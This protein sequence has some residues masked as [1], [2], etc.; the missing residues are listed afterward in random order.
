MTSPLVPVSWSRSYQAQLGARL[1]AP[2]LLH[3]DYALFKAD[4][5]Y[6]LMERDAVLAAAFDYRRTLAAGTE[7]HLEPASPAPV[8]RKVAAILESLLR[9]VERFGQ[10][11]YLLANAVIRGESWAGIRGSWRELSAAG[12]AVRRWWVVD[13]LVDVDK[14]RFQTTKESAGRYCWQIQRF[15]PYGLETIDRRHYVRHVHN[16]YEATL[17]RGEGCGPK[18]FEY[19]KIKAELLRC[20]MQFVDRTGTPNLVAKVAM[21]EGDRRDPNNSERLN[22]WLKVLTRMRA[23]NVAAYDAQDEIEYLE[24]QGDGS[25]I[26]LAVSYVDEAMTREVLGATLPTGGGSG[27]GSYAR[28]DV[29]ADVV[30]AK[31]AADRLGL[32]ESLTRDLV[33]LIYEANWPTILLETQ[34]VRPT[35]VPELRLR[36]DRREAP[37]VEVATIEKLLGLGVPL[38]QDEVYARTRFTPPA[39]S[40]AVFEARPTEPPAE[41]PRPRLTEAA[42][43]GLGFG[44]RSVP[45]ASESVGP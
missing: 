23:G 24:V 4:D 39:A 1:Y 22:S 32:E 10:A 30:H 41:R 43:A 40:D 31:T 27:A 16:A 25:S 29:E 20:W 19:F 42:A 17:G 8:D 3:V 38:R 2:Y 13:E 34:G 44:F 35:G 9:R 21:D 15:E 36:Q 7:W 33:A 14:R 12:G 6:E 45:P 37:S 11:R 26:R 18:V 5:A 28:A